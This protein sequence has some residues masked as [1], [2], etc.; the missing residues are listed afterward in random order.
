MQSTTGGRDN[1]F[2]VA[3]EAG[4]RLGFRITDH[5]KLTVGYTGI[6]WS[7]V[8]RAPEQFNLSN[9]PTGGVTH[10]YTNMMSLGGEVRY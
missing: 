5:A 3:A 6:Y 10:I 9:S 8:R 2:S 4:V 7:N 1:L